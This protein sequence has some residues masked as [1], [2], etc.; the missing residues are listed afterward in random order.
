MQK[1]LSYSDI[2]KVYGELAKYWDFVSSPLEFVTGFGRLRRKLANEAY[3]D[4][5]EVAAGTGRNFEYYPK[6]CRIT[7]VDLSKE[8]LK[9]AAKK[10]EKL[11]KII[12]LQTGSAEMLK[13][14]DNSFDCVV[15]TLALCTYLD[16]IK[17]L[18]EMRRVCKK[19]GK[20]LLL[21]HGI[22][23]NPLIRK[24]QNWREEPHYEKMG[25]H[26]T[27]NPSEIVRKAE[28][29][30]EKERRY[31]LGNGLYFIIAR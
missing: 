22:S 23:D 13:F 24:W 18:R 16:P 17:A 10:S 19:D 2:A 14:D 8:M 7:A 29:N 26:L 6:D 9:K 31:G 21:E 3:G 30:I 12:H 4:V 5:L 15:E 25:C 20:I 11:G 28:L 1:E 27:R